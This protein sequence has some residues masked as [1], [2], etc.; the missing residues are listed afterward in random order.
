[1]PSQGAQIPVVLL[2]LKTI[3][4]RKGL[5]MK[6]SKATRKSRPSAGGKRARSRKSLPAR[7]RGRVHLHIENPPSPGE[8]FE[9]TRQRVEKALA[10]YPALRKRI[11]ITIGYDG[12]ILN[13][14]LKTA[15]VLFGWSFDRSNLAERAPNLRWIHAHGAGVNHL[16]PLDW[17]PP[18]AVLTNSRGVHGSK[19]DEYAIM[20]I[21]MLN[22]RVPEMVASQ[23]R[24]TWNQVFNTSIEGKTLLIVGVG[25][26]GRGAAKWAKRFGLNVIGIRRTG[27][28]HR[29]VDAMHRPSAL[30]RLLPSADF[31]L[32]TAPHTRDSHHMIGARE[33]ALLKKGAGIANYSRANLV[34]YEALRG[35]LEKGELS[36]I[37]DVFDPEPLPSESW[38]WH[39]PNLIITPHCSSDD[40]ELYTIKTLDLVFR[41]MKR[42]IAGKP[43]VN[44]V[45]AR[46]QY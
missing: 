27:K 23:R 39:A 28:P 1:V 46:Y 24:A 44:R 21:L 22:N 3:E 20:S 8:V 2:R 19:A 40:R 10:S 41:N 38:L 45:D 26:V 36:A 6:A 4:Q 35:R 34:D 29:Y 7:T 33:I 11:E 9:V 13:G 30:R 31:V 25:H 12:D 43:L 17:L 42:F 15:D 5:A 14:A 18:G 37:L 32:I 16:M